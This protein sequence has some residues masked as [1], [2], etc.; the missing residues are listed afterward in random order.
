MTY[1]LDSDLPMP[2]GWFD[3]IEYEGDDRA[4]NNESRFPADYTLKWRHFDRNAFERFLSRNRS[5]LKSYAA[6]P[7]VAAWVASHCSTPSKRE[8][9]AYE[10]AK[11][12]DLA[13]YGKCGQPCDRFRLNGYVLNSLH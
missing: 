1:N 2:Y 6:R 9:Y 4:K 12:I 13:V 7:R 5:T 8:D 10:L 11:H 3:P